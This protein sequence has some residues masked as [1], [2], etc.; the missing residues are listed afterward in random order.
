MLPGRISQKLSILLLFS[1]ISPSAGQDSADGQPTSSVIFTPPAWNDPTFGVNGV[2]VSRK[3]D[4]CNL[5]RSVY[6][7]KTVEVRDAL[8]N[9]TLSTV[10]PTVAEYELEGLHYTDTNGVLTD[11][12]L[13]TEIFAELSRRAG[14]NWRRA[15]GFFEP[16]ATSP[17]TRNKTWTDILYW[18]AQNYDVSI[19]WY[20]DLTTHKS[21][22]YL[23]PEHWF[24]SSLI[25]VTKGKFVELPIMERA[26]S[27]LKPF[28][29]ELWTLVMVS[30]VFAGAVYWFLEQ[31]GLNSHEF[32]YPTN[33]Q[34]MCLSITYTAL[35]WGGGK[36]HH[37]H[38]F[39][40]RIFTFVWLFVRLLFISMYTAHLASSFVSN[41][42]TEYPVT[43][44]SQA[45]EKRYPICIEAASE[46]LKVIST[47]Y[48]SAKL[49]P[50][51]ERDIF[52]NM[53]QGKCTCL[54]PLPD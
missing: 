18:T 31:G 43:S 8:R 42:L 36:W 21:K 51:H 29:L 50:V 34:N 28:T 40:G 7:D 26:F 44:L 13:M 19:G 32:S 11:K 23:F 15:Y 35:E 39:A 6:V 24:D 17:A 45:I 48:R 1:V 46:P 30:W 14:F 5:W 9:Q 38:T 10:W 53:E 12:G 33:W 52:A 2:S 49:V 27:F 3:H 37:P 20:P 16:P 22:G 41:T 4:L 47:L 25:M 54:L